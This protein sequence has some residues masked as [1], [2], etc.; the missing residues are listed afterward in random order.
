MRLVY[1]KGSGFSDLASSFAALGGF[2]V[3]FNTWAVISYRKS[4]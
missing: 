4:A 2:A 3:F 1:L